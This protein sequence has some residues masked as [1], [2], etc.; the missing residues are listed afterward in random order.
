M[1]S[2]FPLISVLMGVYYRSADVGALQ[3]SV[4]SILNQT[5]PDLELMICAD[6]SS[7]EALAYL[8]S[9]AQSDG[10]LRLVDK[11]GAHTLPVKL[12]ACFR[13]SRGAFLARMDD[14]DVSH[15]DR[16]EKQLEA[17]RTHR[18]IAFVGSSAVLYRGGA[19]VGERRFPERP[20]VR[21][22]YMTQPY[23]HPAL[24]FR[25]AAL[26]AA[27]GYSEDRRCVLCEDYDLL[28]RL[29][30]KGLTG[31][32]LAEP[33]L[34]Y[35]LSATAKGSRT[36]AHRRNEAV[37]RWRRFRELGVLGQAWPYVFKPIAV[38]LLPEG[39]LARIKERRTQAGERSQDERAT[40]YENGADPD[41]RCSHL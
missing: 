29:Y 11:R 3:R 10:R 15:A 38:G 12:N 8:E 14:D 13:A 37:T 21:D 9:A 41:N 17:L 5:V 33:L 6:G 7:P 22:F 30:A 4:E 26:E 2:E 36:M 19:R 31:M 32:N 20:A 39:L 23:L 35:T 1:Y 27:G 25:R 40:S 28:L 16:F 24:V 34:D 18:E